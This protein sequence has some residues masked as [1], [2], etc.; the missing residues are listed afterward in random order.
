M[1]NIHVAAEGELLTIRVDLPGVAKDLSRQIAEWQETAERNRQ[2]W[3]QSEWYLGEARASIARLEEELEAIR[4]VCAQLDTNHRKTTARLEETAR[5]RDEAREA[6]SEHTGRLEAQLSRTVADAVEAR[7]VIAER[8]NELAVER[9]RCIALETELV[10]LRA[11]GERRRTSR[12]FRPDLTMEV[13]GPDG[14]VLFQGSPRNV[15]SRGVGFASDRPIDDD[16][17]GL[18]ITLRQ[19]GTRPIEA[20][21]RV[22]WQA[23]DTMSGSVG[24]CELLDM[25]PGCR[26]I[27]DRVLAAEP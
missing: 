22:A 10:A 8:Q 9:S 25:S 17:G 3:E 13:Q 5:E 2:Q 21:G 7:R 23:P 26:E 15:S 24:G 1:N 16:S 20:L 4:Q 11:H 18:W 6:L 14:A 27:F 19:P 12:R